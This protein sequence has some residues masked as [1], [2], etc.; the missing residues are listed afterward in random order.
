MKAVAEKYMQE[1]KE[2]LE[3]TDSLDTVIQVNEKTI[4]EKGKELIEKKN[5]ILKTKED[6]DKDYEK[7]KKIIDYESRFTLNEETVFDLVKGYDPLHDKW[8]KLESKRAAMEACI[9]QI[10][11]SYED[12]AIALEVF[13]EITRKLFGKIFK[14][15]FKKKELE[16]RHKARKNI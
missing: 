14:T 16:T 12:K 3:E 6:L 9:L 5:L 4:E 7:M 2:T 15:I 11:K 1:V 13:L 8:I 10:K